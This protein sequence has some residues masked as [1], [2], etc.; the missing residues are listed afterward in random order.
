MRLPH[1]NS[2]FINLNQLRNHSL[3][4]ERDRGKHL[5]IKL[6]SSTLLKLYGDSNNK[7]GKHLV[8]AK[9]SVRHFDKTPKSLALKVFQRL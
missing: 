5:I 7:I 8:S 6:T 2:T 1:V 4:P 9:F 3:N